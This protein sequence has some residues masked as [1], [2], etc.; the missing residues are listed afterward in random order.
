MDAAVATIFALMPTDPSSVS[1]GGEL[2]L[3]LHQATGNDVVIDA[4]SFVP[5]RV[6]PQELA[7]MK[8]EG[9]LWGRKVAT[10]PTILAVLGTAQEH[11]GTWSLQRLMAPAIEIARRGFELGYYQRMAMR[12]YQKILRANPEGAS[13]LRFGPGGTL[14]PV[15]TRIIFPGLATTFQRL[16]EAGWRDFYRGRLATAIESDMR[17]HGGW[18]TRADLSRV[19]RSVT[20]SEPLETRYRG[21]RILTPGR[22]WGGPALS[23]ALE[24]LRQLPAGLL[25]SD[26]TNHV[27]LMIEAVRLAQFDQIRERRRNLFP[28]QALRNTSLPSGAAAL[29]QAI[30]FSRKVPI[31]EQGA[32]YAP[33]MGDRNTIHIDVLDTRGNA[34]AATLTLGRFFG[35]HTGSPDLGF[36]YNSLMES[37]QYDNPRGP[38]YPRPLAQLHSYLT[39]TIALGKNGQILVLGTGGSGRITS[40]VLEVLSNVL[41]RDMPLEEAVAHPRVA[42]TGPE[43]RTVELEAIPPLRPGIAA[44]LRRRGFGNPRVITYPAIIDDRAHMGGVDCASFDPATGLYTGVGDPR[45]EGFASAPGGRYGTTA[46]GEAP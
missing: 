33:P 32:R 38:Q 18:I 1:P 30:D 31:E 34:V 44:E 27:H 26:S 23:E 4:P 9:R 45:R 17:R 22:P 12:E 7:D 13:M 15:G 20:I 14:P 28:G 19:P 3:V 29:A 46:G 37:F 25:T 41:D 2:V 36:F 10:V 43:E 8:R 39:P 16:A 40:F 24:I 6:Q 11:F 21:H 42:W 35:C 5:M